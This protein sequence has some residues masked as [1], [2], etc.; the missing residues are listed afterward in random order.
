MADSIRS[1]LP[2]IVLM[3]IL[4]FFIIYLILI[5]PTERASVLQAENSTS[6]GVVYIEDKQFLPD[7]LTIQKG[8]SIT[9]INKD[10][11]KHRIVG[12]DFKSGILLTNNKYSHTFDETGVYVYS[13]EFYPGAV[14]KI[15]VE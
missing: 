10:T 1:G 12:A 4:A 14:G 5:S 15:I 8:D 7:E 2:P 3:S 13:S 9:W 11:V 6:T